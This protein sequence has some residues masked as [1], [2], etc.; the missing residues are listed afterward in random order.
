[1]MI[2]IECAVSGVKPGMVEKEGWQ[3]RESAFWDYS[4]YGCCVKGPCGEVYTFM[5]SIQEGIERK[6]L[7][8]REV[9]AER[10]GKNRIRIQVE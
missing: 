1:M 9:V 5:P 2:E 6:M 4:N 8:G 3:F 10:I 7:C